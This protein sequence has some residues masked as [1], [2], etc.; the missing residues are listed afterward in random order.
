MTGSVNARLLVV[1]ARRSPVGKFLLGSLTQT[2]ILEAEVP[3]LVVKSA[4]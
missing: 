3:I 2:L 4:S 1:G